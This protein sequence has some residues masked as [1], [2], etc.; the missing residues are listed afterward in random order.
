MTRSLMCVVLLLTLS[1]PGFAQMDRTNPAFYVVLNALT[2]NCTVVDKLPHTDTLNITVASD[3]VYK[4]RTEAEAA[5]K[6][7]APC[8]Q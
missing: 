8:K 3:A 6:T 7:P 1:R 2:R 5:A 4:T